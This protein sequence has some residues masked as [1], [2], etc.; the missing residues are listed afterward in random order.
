MGTLSVR[1]A[2]RILGNVETNY[3]REMFERVEGPRVARAARFKRAKEHSPVLV[4]PTT[5]P[6]NID[7][8]IGITLMKGKF[9]GMREIRV[10]GF[11]DPSEHHCREAV[12]AVRKTVHDVGEALE[13]NPRTRNM[14]ITPSADIAAFDAC[15]PST[16]EHSIEDYLISQYDESER[17][18]AVAAVLSSVLLPKVADSPS[19]QN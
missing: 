7:R 17:R 14:V 13:S 15:N 16:R 8:E 19:L 1:T 2:Q 3:I 4:V 11:V 6:D 5:D 18:V 9:S 10:Q 12:E